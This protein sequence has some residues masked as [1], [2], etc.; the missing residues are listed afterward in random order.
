MRDQPSWTAQSV[1]TELL[2]MANDGRYRYLVPDD[3]RELTATILKTIPGFRGL[4]AA[5]SM[6]PG[7]QRLIGFIERLINPNKALYLVL[8][9]CWIEEQVRLCLSHGVAQVVIL[10][11]GFDTLAY[12]IHKDFS[13][14]VWFEVDHPATQKVKTAGLAHCGQVEPNLQFLA[15]DF[16]VEP[17]LAT[18]ISHP[19]FDQRK[20]NA[21][22]CRRFI[23]LFRTRN[24]RRNFRSPPKIQWKR[25]LS[26]GDNECPKNQLQPLD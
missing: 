24:H 18:L 5:F 2:I 11:A 17:D 8:R 19:L 6:H 13:N 4:F 15:C 12:R 1:A 9:K 14:V 22:H 26:L 7:L 16:S 3:V 23:C 20:K 10:G 25:Q 21:L